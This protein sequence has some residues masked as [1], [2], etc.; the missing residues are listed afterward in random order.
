[1]VSS[2]ASR[3]GHDVHVC[4]EFSPARS[5]GLSIKGWDPGPI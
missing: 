1:M 5:P 4:L 3:R 2:R